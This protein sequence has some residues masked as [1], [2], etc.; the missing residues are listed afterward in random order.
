MSNKITYDEFIDR[1]KESQNLI[2][3]IGEYVG[4]TNPMKYKCLVCGYEWK[5][6]EARSAIRHGCWNC[7]RKIKSIKTAKAKTKSEEQFRLEL[8]LVQ[9]NLI[10]NDKYINGST[11]YHCICKIH[12]CDVYTTPE[13]MLHRNQGCPICAIERNKCATRYTDETYRAKLKSINSNIEV[14]SAYISIKNRINAK[15]KICGHIWN[16]IAESLISKHPC[17]CP[18]C[19]S[20]AIKTPAEFKSEL[21][22]SHP[23]LILL[24]DYNRS[25][26]KVH[27]KCT[28]C[29]NDFWVTPNKLQ[30]GQQCNCKNESHGEY[31]IRLFL[32]SNNIVYESQKQFDGLYGQSG[33]RKLSYDFYIP[34]QKLLIEYNGEQHRYPSNFGNKSISEDEMNNIL[35]RQKYHDRLKKEYALSNNYSLLTIWY[36]DYK[37]IES[38]LK[39]NLIKK[40]S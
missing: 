40:V 11:K 39:E 38:I 21:S 36:W 1:L 2:I 13:K 35:N 23:Y 33:F 8:S 25:S 15:C 30:Q 34:S 12:G 24:S 10:P 14:L 5:T 31:K 20:N 19:A 32:E 3:P 37:N 28:H 18:K 7:S 27:V 17:G 22:I 26:K 29:G 6:T 4:W 9:P 16:P